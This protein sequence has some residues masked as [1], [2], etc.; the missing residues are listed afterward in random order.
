MKV[1]FICKGN[2]GRSQ[3]AEA[4]F[5]RLSKLN[6]SVS[7]GADPG[8]WDGQ[9]I[10]ELVIK[11][12][13]DL[14]YD[15]SLNRAKRITKEMV[16]DA[17]KIIAICKMEDLPDYVKDSGKLENWDVVDPKGTSYE[18]HA[19]IRDEIKRLVEKLVKEI[20]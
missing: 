12:M 1:L 3:M 19:K 18:F 14:G 17:D 16:E 11:V 15:L 20:G 4:L 10:H 8:R 2:V 5:N 6:H 13:A 9:I 7:A